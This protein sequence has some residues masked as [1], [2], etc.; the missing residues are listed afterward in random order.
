MVQDAFSGNLMYKLHVSVVIRREGRV[1]LVQEADEDYGLWNLPGGHVEPAETI[2]QAALREVWEETGLSVL[3]DSFLGVYPG[4][5]GKS[6]TAVRF[7]FTASIQ[8]GSTPERPGEDILALGWFHQAEWLALPPTALLS[9]R[10]LHH[11][12]TTDVAYPL[13]AVIEE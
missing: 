3:L 2:K 13:S 11:I 1:L 10:T 5:A 12:L 4:F 8:D 7:V 9:A 6:R